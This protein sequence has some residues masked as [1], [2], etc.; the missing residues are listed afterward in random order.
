MYSEVP[1]LLFL[2]YCADAV[3][4]IVL[5]DDVQDDDDGYDDDDGGCADHLFSLFWIG[6][7][8]ELSNLIGQ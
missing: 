3:W 1:S 8:D 4:A 6:C 2:L 7:S 5:E